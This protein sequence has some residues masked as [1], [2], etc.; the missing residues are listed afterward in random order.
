[1]SR[2]HTINA[3]V[4]KLPEAKSHQVHLLNGSGKRVCRC[5]VSKADYFEVEGAT[6]QRDEVSGELYLDKAGSLLMPT[7]NLC[8]KSYNTMYLELKRLQKW[9]GEK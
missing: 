6:L 8:E 9:N 3:L 7:V 5:R 4:A 1:M 2:T